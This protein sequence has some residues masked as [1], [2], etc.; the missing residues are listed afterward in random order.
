MPKPRSID[1]SGVGTRWNISKEQKGKG[2]E[3][4][5]AGGRPWEEGFEESS[6]SLGLRREWGSIC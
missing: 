4:R 2:S 6:G 1:K 3:V 5:R